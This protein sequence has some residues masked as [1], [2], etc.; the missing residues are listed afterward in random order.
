M[1]GLCETDRRLVNE[2]AQLWVG[3][4]GDSEGVVWLWRAIKDRVQE[5]EVEL[6]GKVK[7]T[8]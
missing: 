5:I 4:G 6:Q 7:E 2:I 8:Q 1:W 3:S